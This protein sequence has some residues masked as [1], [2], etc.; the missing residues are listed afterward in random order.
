MKIYYWFP[1]LHVSKSPE[2]EKKRIRWVWAFEKSEIQTAAH[3]CPC[4]TADLLPLS[5]VT[6]HII[7]CSRGFMRRLHDSVSFSFFWEFRQ[8][9][10]WDV[11]TSGLVSVPTGETLNVF[12]CQ[13]AD[14]DQSLTKIKAICRPTP[15]HS[16]TCGRVGPKRGPLLDH[17]IT[18]AAHTCTPHTHLTPHAPSPAVFSYGSLLSQH[19]VGCLCQWW[20]HEGLFP[21]MDRAISTSW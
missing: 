8:M 4:Q 18:S 20:H 11:R 12:S 21:L 9:A 16:H 1:S 17:D 15:T 7:R 2:E 5:C 6:V 3:Y 19:A 13:W 14:V 10:L